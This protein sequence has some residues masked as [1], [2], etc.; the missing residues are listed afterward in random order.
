MITYPPI[1]DKSLNVD[2]IN[3]VGSMKNII[4]DSCDVVM[5]FLSKDIHKGQKDMFTMGHTLR[6]S[7]GGV[8]GYIIW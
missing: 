5:S 7:N 1:L 3:K 2:S 6:N 4:S 8:L